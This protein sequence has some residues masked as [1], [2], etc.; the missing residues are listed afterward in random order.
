MELGDERVG[1]K[2]NEFLK[3]FIFYIKK[4]KFIFEGV[5]KLIKKRQ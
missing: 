5:D 4:Q 2:K 1:S 3:G